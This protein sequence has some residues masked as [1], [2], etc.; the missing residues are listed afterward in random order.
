MTSRRQQILDIAAELFAARGF[1]GVSVSELGAACGISGPALYKH[2][3]SKDAVLAEMLVSISET[4]LAEGRSRVDGAEGPRQ[5][6]EALIEWHI[7]FAL[8][9]RALIVVQDRDWSSLPDEA[10][11]RVRA[12]Q[13]AYVDV[14]ATQVR[15]H[16]TSLSPEASR[17]RAHVLFGLLNSTPHSGRLPDPQM[18]DV[19]REMAHGALGLA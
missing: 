16:D 5:A 2:F 14:W 4:L 18:H 10:R 15:R 3:E 1:H 13:R 11:E 12:L 19:L 9:H 8:D 6:L 17:T 7:E